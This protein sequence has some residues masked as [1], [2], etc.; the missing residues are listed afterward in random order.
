MALLRDVEAWPAA[1]RSDADPDAYTARLVAPPHTG[2]AN[3][4]CVVRTGVAAA[5]EGLAF[6]ALDALDARGTHARRGR[7]ATD[8]ARQRARGV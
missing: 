8:P 1:H 6:S 2:H 7:C 5:A 3:A 4:L